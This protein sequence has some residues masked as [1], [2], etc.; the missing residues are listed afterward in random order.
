M[1]TIRW[2]QGRMNEVAES[3]R[4]HGEQHPLIARW[5]N[6]FWAVETGADAAAREEVERH[7]G[8]GFADLP[9]NGFWIIHLC[10]LA[11]ACV[12]RRTRIGT[13][14]PS[15]SCPMARLPYASA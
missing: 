3:V 12:L 2:A 9:R 5:R 11:E 7:A 13:P 8:N 1:V 10:S 14:S 6:A 15:R 4:I